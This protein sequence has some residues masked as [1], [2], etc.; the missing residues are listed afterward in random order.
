VFF[1]AQLA[2]ACFGGIVLPRDKLYHRVSWWFISGF[3]TMGFLR[4]LL[5][6]YI[7]WGSLGDYFWFLYHYIMG[8][9]GEYY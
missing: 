3:Y 9:P 5:L 7:P 8:F 6:V 2:D 1:S 4:G